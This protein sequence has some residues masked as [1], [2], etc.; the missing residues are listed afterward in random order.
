[1]GLFFIWAV[2]VAVGILITITWLFR[3]NAHWRNP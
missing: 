1:M 3:R 2:I